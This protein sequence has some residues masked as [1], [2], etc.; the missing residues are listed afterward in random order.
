MK[1]IKNEA[2]ELIC[3]RCKHFDEFGGGCEAFPAGIPQEIVNG[4]NMHE[5][6]LEDQG[7]EIVFEPL[8]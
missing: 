2:K 5:K 7:N 4:D 3:L 1:T 8:D 6:P